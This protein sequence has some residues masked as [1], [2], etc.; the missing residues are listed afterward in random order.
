MECVFQDSHII[1][2]TP[3][4]NLFGVIVRR[5][6]LILQGSSEEMVRETVIVN[7]VMA[8]RTMRSTKETKNN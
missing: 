2:D 8:I 6:G 1:R 4:Q 5:D 3:L 7:N